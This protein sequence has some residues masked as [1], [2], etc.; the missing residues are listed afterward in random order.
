MT[1]KFDFSDPTVLA[2]LK[3]RYPPYWNI[4]QYC[5]H[6]G[7]CKRSD[8]H[9]RWYA[10][11]RTKKGNYRQ[12]VIGLASKA[13]TPGFTFDEALVAAQQWFSSSEIAPIASDPYAVGSKTGLNYCPWGLEFTIG[14]ALHD[15]IEWKRLAANKATFDSL[16]SLVNHHILSRL[17]YLQLD[18]FNGRHVKQFYLEVLET[19]P[20]RGTQIMG[21]RRKLSEMTDDELRCRKSTLNTLV[22]ILRLS[23]K[24]AWEN[25]E[26]NSERAWKCIR[27]LPNR[28]RPR[29]LFLSREECRQLLFHCRPDLKALVLGGLYTGCR[30]TEL[31]RLL[32]RDVATK[33]FGIYVSSP[34]GGTPRFVFLPDEGMAFFLSITKGRSP[35]D[36]AFVHQDSGQWRGRHKHLFRDVV[37]RAKLPNG[38]VFHGLR[39]TYASQLVQA[40]TPII[41]VAQQLGHATADTVARTYGHLAPQI[42]EAQ[43]RHNFAPLASEFETLAADMRAELDSISARL[44]P[45]DWRKYAELEPQNSWPKSNYVANFDWSRNDLRKD[46]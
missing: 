27:R 16:V 25:G 39:H 22:G 44:K 17:G 45:D 6:F 34:K 21:G 7:V 5:R 37:E 4:I 10:R 1:T 18:D 31:D 40:A 43:I 42:R 33:V 3:P 36:Y 46:D 13:G 23:L 12:H 9:I 41:V 26:T 29:M 14:H 19:P 32:V 24:L 11:V 28:H 30:V 38:F 20:K 8:N 15:Y 35:D 2:A